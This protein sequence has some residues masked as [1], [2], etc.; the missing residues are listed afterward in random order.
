MPGT[1]IKQAYLEAA[2]L[3]PSQGAAQDFCGPIF[4]I[5]TALA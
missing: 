3:A 5:G 2:G 4:E 1:D